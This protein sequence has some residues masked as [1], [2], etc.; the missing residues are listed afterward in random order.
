MALLIPTETPE[1][2]ESQVPRR[3]KDW[4]SFH[5]TYCYIA[6]SGEPDGNFNFSF[7][8]QSCCYVFLSQLFLQRRTQIFKIHNI[9]RKQ[10]NLSVLIYTWGNKCTDILMDLLMATKKINSRGSIWVQDLLAPHAGLIPQVLI[11]FWRETNLLFFSSPAR[12]LP[13]QRLWSRGPSKVL[14]DAWK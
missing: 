7:Y 13:Q 3:G 2:A 5:I 11:Y 4:G 9:T 8:V 10:R 14:D 1:L 6:C 12:K